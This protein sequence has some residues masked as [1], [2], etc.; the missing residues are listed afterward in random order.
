VDEA[1]NRYARELIDAINAAVGR[2]PEVQACR[3][4]ARAAGFE[5]KV[6]L[7]AAV[8]FVDSNQPVAHGRTTTAVPPSR[9]LMPAAHV[10]EITAADRRFLRSLRIA[11]SEPT[12]EL[13]LGGD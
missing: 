1:V 7:E 5:M 10:Y 11:A 8:G 3:E 2:D 6:S 12:G 9:R 4:R 13:N